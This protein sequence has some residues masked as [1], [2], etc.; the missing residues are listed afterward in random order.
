MDLDLE[1]IQVLITAAKSLVGLGKDVKDFIPDGKKKQEFEQS[2]SAVAKAADLS[3][4]QIAAILGFP[5]CR[6]HFPPGI[7]V[8]LGIRDGAE[9]FECQKCH[10]VYP[11]P[12][13]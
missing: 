4:A 12:T 5:L 6:R 8:S 9:E 10:V 11:P 2:L 1:K 7:C 3:D 13:P